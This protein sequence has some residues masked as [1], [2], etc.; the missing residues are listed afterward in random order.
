[1]CLLDAPVLIEYLFRI[2]GSTKAHQLCKHRVVP[3]VCELFHIT[4]YVW[5]RE[6]S[7]AFWLTQL[8]Y[9]ARNALCHCSP[10]NARGTHGTQSLAFAV[11]T[12]FNTVMCRVEHN[13]M[14]I[15]IVYD[16]IFCGFPAK[17]TVY[18][19]YMTV[20]LVVT[21]PKIPYGYGQP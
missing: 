16:C 15:H 12:L 20:Y 2:S 9:I 3:C 18:T 8:P 10:N 11:L 19:P 14:Y 13:R 6:R 7:N 17:N 5:T 21:L 1:M 4:C